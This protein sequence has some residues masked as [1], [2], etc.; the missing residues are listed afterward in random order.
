MRACPQVAL[1]GVH[2]PVGDAFPDAA[3]LH[4]QHAGSPPSQGPASSATSS[5]SVVS[6][7]ARSPGSALAQLDQPAVARHPARMT[8]GT[9]KPPSTAGSRPANWCCR[10]RAPQLGSALR[11]PPAR[12]CNAVSRAGTSRR[13]VTSSKTRQSANR[14]LLRNISRSPRR[15]SGWIGKCPKIASAEPKP[16]RCTARGAAIRDRARCCSIAAEALVPARSVTRHGMAPQRR[17]SCL[18]HARQIR[19][20]ISGALPPQQ[21]QDELGHVGK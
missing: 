19:V 1:F 14:T 18:G 5:S 2:M 11:P 6:T 4:Q 9:A 12:D 7:T 3:A 13:R 17:A 15:K 16:T 20:R 21:D 10:T 8:C